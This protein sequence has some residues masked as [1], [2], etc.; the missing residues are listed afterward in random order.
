MT[1]RYLPSDVS[2][3]IHQII[4]KAMFLRAS[5][6]AVGRQQAVPTQVILTRTEM[7]MAADAAFEYDV[8]E[9]GS[10]LFRPARD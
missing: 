6:E 1:H 8:H 10:I 4:A 5:R 2:S 9:D 3:D 7:E